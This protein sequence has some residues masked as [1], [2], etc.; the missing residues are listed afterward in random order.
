MLDYSSKRQELDFDYY[1]IGIPTN[2]GNGSYLQSEGLL[3]VRKGVTDQGA[4]SAF[5]EQLL[6]EEVQNP[7]FQISVRNLDRKIW[8]DHNGDPNLVI[9]SYTYSSIPTKKDGSTFVKEFQDF[10]LRCVPA[11]INDQIIYDMIL[12]ETYEY[13]EGNRDIYE[14]AEILQKRVT[15]YLEEKKLD[16]K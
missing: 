16:N 5:L 15:L 3:V 14:T 10:L 2:S 6:S 12:M 9:N 11:P 13:F 4:V 1:E 8:V 7:L